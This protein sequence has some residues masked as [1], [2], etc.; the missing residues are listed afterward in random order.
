M[1]IDNAHYHGWQGKLHSPWWSSLAIVRVA[2][3]QVFRRKSYWV[4]LGLGLFNF[5]VFW[6]VIYAVTQF[7]LPAEG[8]EVLLSRFGF[9]AQP[10][11]DRE[12]GYV[13]F[14]Q[15]QSL[16]VMV[17]LAFCGSLIVGS[18]FRM[19]ALPFYLS[20]RIDRQ[21]Y[22]FGKLLAVAVIV[23][24]LTLVP[25]LALW[26]E[27]GMFTSSLAYWRESWR[28]LLSFVTYGLVLSVVLSVWLVTLSAYLQ[29]VAPIAITWSS[30]FV[31][32]AAMAGK[33]R[34][35]SGNKYWELI[36]PW[37]D[38]RYTSRLI[39]DPFPTEGYRE[40]ALWAV[41]ILVGTCLVAL[42]AL[43]RRVRAVEIVT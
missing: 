35:A 31:L 30:L 2:I 1:G 36:D 19:N 24:L 15:R 29:R 7:E 40:L 6:S 11:P 21:H 43:A 25:A 4:V 41:A 14:M 20:R 28:V 23:A 3:L 27:Y 26:I 5:F 17:L 16:I 34:E 12:S 32:L 22:I 9:S 8:Q 10:V 33:L 13:E 42:V 37:K 38:M 18:D 39:Y